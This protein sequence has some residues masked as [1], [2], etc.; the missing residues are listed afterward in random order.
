MEK[1]INGWVCEERFEDLQKTLKRCPFCEREAVL[2]VDVY[3]VVTYGA[4]QYRVHCSD[5]GDPV[6]DCGVG[7]PATNTPEYAVK[8]WNR[9]GG[10]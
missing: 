3:S 2:D 1:T 9:R 10:K 6:I 8:I 4:E 7:T 5:W